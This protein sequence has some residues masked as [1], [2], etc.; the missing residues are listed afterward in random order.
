MSHTALKCSF[1]IREPNAEKIPVH[2]FTGQTLGPIVWS[3]PWAIW[4]VKCRRYNCEQT[5]VPALWT[6]PDGIGRVG[7]LVGFLEP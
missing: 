2:A 4:C 3:C 6:H 7:E 1:E 5:L